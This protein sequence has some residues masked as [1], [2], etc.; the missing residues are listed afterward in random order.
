MTCYYHNKDLDGFCSGAI[1]RLAYP[2]AE[3][4]GYDYGQP[5]EMPVN[6]QPVVMADVS[7]PMSTMFKVAQI[8]NFQFT[9]IDHHKSAISD[10]QNWLLDINRSYEDKTK[11]PINAVLQEGIA[12]CEIAWNYFNPDSEMPLVVRYLGEYDTWRSQDKDHWENTVLP[13]QFGMRKI[14]NSL[15]TFPT[16]LLSPNAK[17]GTIQT[18]INN[19]NTIL[20]YQAQINETQCR[21]AFEFD[22]NGIR[23]ICLNT[24]GFNSDTF[25]SVWDEDKYDVMIPFQF[26]GQMWRVSLYSTKAEIDCSAIAKSMGGGG[27]KGAAGFKVESIEKFLSK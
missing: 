12:A 25:K 14:C 10:Y 16:G 15:E 2:N 1:M 9:W 19:G 21:N 8:S 22:F 7:L 13:F 4:I 26:D 24:G 18:I 17:I 20:N 6:G 27:H 23:A 5:F 11:S 3:F